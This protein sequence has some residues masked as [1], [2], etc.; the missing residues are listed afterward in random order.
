MPKTHDDGLASR[1]SGY[2]GWIT[3]IQEVKVGVKAFTGRPDFGSW[4][5]IYLFFFVSRVWG[6]GVSGLRLRVWGFGVWALGR[7]YP[8]QSLNPKL[9]Q[10]KLL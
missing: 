3:D 4:S 1:Q 6:F 2:K 7:L 5:F 9:Y 8:P 10:E